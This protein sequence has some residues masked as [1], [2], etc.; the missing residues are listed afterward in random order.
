[1]TRRRKRWRLRIARAATNALRGFIS[2]VGVFKVTGIMPHAEAPT[3]PNIL[4]AIDATPRFVRSPPPSSSSGSIW[5][6]SQSKRVPETHVASVP[7]GVAFSTGAVFDPAG[8]FVEMASHDYDSIDDPRRI[9][10]GFAPKPH[11]SFPTIHRLP[12]QVVALTA[13]NQEFYFH[14]IFDVLPR[15]W[16]AEKA[17]YG[18]GP[19]FVEARLPFQRRT[20]RALGVTGA[21]RI[22]A[23]E[24]TAVSAANLIVPCHRIVPGHLFPEWAIHFLRDRL[25]PDAG[26]RRSPVRRLYLSRKHA[27]HRRVVNEPEVVSFLGEY[28]FQSIRA[29]DLMFFDQVS[30]FRDAEIII[31]PHGGGLANLVFCAPGAQVIELFPNSN[32]DLYYRLATQLGLDYRFVRSP[33]SPGAFMSSADYRIDP[34]ELKIVLDDAISGRAGSPPR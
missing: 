33:G 22:D 19:F 27:G 12:H 6:A 18:E 3:A 8:R 21:R 28:G 2:P 14:W 31:A 7:D 23:G 26:A 4:S 17:G 10:H 13:S 11:R 32:I 29:E 30:L 1:V 9:R 25:L 20:L 15:L 16:L 5:V 24:V 34:G